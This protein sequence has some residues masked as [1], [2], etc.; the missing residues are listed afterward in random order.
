[1]NTPRFL[2]AGTMALTYEMFGSSSTHSEGWSIET[3][4]ASL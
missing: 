2:T 4:I 3:Y 1:M